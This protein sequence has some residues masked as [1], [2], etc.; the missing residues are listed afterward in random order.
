MNFLLVVAGIISF[1][2]VIADDTLVLY[3]NDFEQPN[4]PPIVDCGSNLDQTPINTVYGR[5]GQQFGQSKTVET[6]I[7][8]SNWDQ[9]TPYNN[10]DYGQHGKYAVG[11]LSQR[12]DDRLWLDFQVDPNHDFFTVEMDI[13]AIDVNG[14]GGPFSDPNNLLQPRFQLTLIDRD[15][16]AV[17]ESHEITGKVPPNQWTYNWS[18]EVETFNKGKQ[19]NVR[20]EWNL[21]HPGSEF[22]VLDNLNIYTSVIPPMASFSPVIYGD[23]HIKTWSGEMYDFHGSC[24]LVMLQN[25]SFGMGIGMDIHIRTK[26]VSQEWSCISAAALRIGENTFEVMGGKENQYWIDGVAGESLEKGVAGHAIS[27]K[28][29]NSVSR[30]F[31]VDLYDGESINFKVWRN[32]VRVDLVSASKKNYGDS[33]GLLGSFEKGHKIGRDKSTVF[34]DAN[35][36][37]LEWQVLAEEPKLFHSLEGAQAPTK[38]AMPDT[39]TKVRRRRLLD[40]TISLEDAGIACAHVEGADRDACIFDVL[41]TNDK[42]TAGAY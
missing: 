29:L 42:D 13:S 10:T 36:F 27:F 15:T 14:C 18:H 16:G 37:G 26:F 31:V 6:V 40:K 12:Q 17:I 19:Q 33:L 38:C 5:T 11:M 41:A 3:E 25:P 20:L 24:D 30:Q 32:F 1:H 9:N 7:L 4:Q 23:P 28:Q 21:L 2:A 35:E 39:A 8:D 22:S 34:D